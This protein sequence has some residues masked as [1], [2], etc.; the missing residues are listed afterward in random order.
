M[1]AVNKAAAALL[2][3]VAA[4]TAY[5]YY[6]RA[7]RPAD[8]ALVA[9]GTVRAVGAVQVRAPLAGQVKE[10]SVDFKTPVKSGQVLARIDATAYEQRVNQ[11]R[12]DL[13]AARAAKATAA[14]RQREASLRQAE[15][16]LERTAIRAPVDGTVILRNADVGQSV[17]AGPQAPVLFTIAP[18]L[19]T[20]QVEAA[21]EA[22]DASHLRPGMRVTFTAD[23]LPRQAF[24]GEIRQVRRG[25]SALAVIDAPNP[26]LALVPGMSVNVRIPRAP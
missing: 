20:V 23:A 10:I 26:D 12:A 3:A 2:A 24:G 1:R 7:S 9:Q 17:T 16:D 6:D 18:D 8:Q 5:V 4:A 15:L 22:A 14:V 19:R 21:L 13:D 11:A 25:A